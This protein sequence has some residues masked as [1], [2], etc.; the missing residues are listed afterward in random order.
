MY[1][2]FTELTLLGKEHAPTSRKKRN[3]TTKTG[4]TSITTK[5]YRVYTCVFTF[6]VLKTIGLFYLCK[7][8]PCIAVSFIFII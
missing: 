7:K 2:I 6:L 3:K 5:A 4:N 8:L 1:L